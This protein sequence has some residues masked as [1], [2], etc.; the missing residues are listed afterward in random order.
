MCLPGI[1]GIMQYVCLIMSVVISDLFHLLI[2]QQ[3]GGKGKDKDNDGERIHKFQD[4]KSRN[5]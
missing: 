5:P 2:L 4:A 1:E 3:S